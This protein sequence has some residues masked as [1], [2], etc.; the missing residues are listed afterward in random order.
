MQHEVAL[1]VTN[2]LPQTPEAGRSPTDSP[3]DSPRAS[4]TGASSRARAGI[5]SSGSR[6]GASAAPRSSKGEAGPSSGRRSPLHQYAPAATAL[7]TNS[8]TK[9]L[10]SSIAAL[11]LVRCLCRSVV[12]AESAMAMLRVC[13]NGD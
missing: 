2:N 12:N 5:T 9:T 6:L 8:D 10:D 3:R 11:G 13:Q 4:A 7:R 1:Q